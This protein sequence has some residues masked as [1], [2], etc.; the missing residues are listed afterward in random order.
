[1]ANKT[2]IVLGATGMLG[3]MVVDVLSRDETLHVIATA[4]S[5]GLVA[6]ACKRVERAEWRTF[7]IRD[8]S[9]TNKSQLNSLGTASWI[10]NAIGIIKPYI[11]DDNPAECERAIM[12]NSMFPH[13]LAHTAEKSGAHVLQI[14]TDCVYSGV[15]GLYVESDKHDA[16]DVYGKTKSL[17]EAL[18]PNIHHLRCS[19]IGPEPKGYVSL[20]EWFLGQPS[21]AEVN[22]FTNH[23]WNGVTTLHFARLCHGIITMNLSLEHIHHVIPSGTISKAELLQSFAHE[24]KRDD[25]TIMPTQA[26]TV[27]NR[28]L[29]TVS[30]EQNNK[31]WDSAGYHVV[32]SVPQMIAELAQFDYSMAEL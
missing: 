32:P 18:L 2:V 8:E 14:A 6:K 21:G 29:A 15:K 16:L 10:V 23:I 1:M 31:L 17:G 19:I 25:I 12:V 9:E 20:L 30:V 7:E 26:K 28:T 4:R 3:S 27:I 22:G 24:Y 11:D 5:E 13:W